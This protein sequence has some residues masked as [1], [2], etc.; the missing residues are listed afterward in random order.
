M[1]ELEHV[2]KLVEGLMSPRCQAFQIGGKSVHDR[3]SFCSGLHVG[4][5]S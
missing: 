5:K 2:Y 4:K 1:I 3:D